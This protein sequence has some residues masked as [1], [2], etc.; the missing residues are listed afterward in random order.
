VKTV[1]LDFVHGFKQGVEEAV[2]GEVTET[3]DSEV[4]DWAAIA[5]N[6]IAAAGEVLS[7]LS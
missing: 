6:V 3:I 2:Q 4:T 5:E 1:S 7:W